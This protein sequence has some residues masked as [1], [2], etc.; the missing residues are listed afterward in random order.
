MS[1][2]FN[3][4][5][6]TKIPLT[7]MSDGAPMPDDSTK[8]PTAHQALTADSAVLAVANSKTAVRFWDS[9]SFKNGSPGTGDMI[10]FTD[11][12]TVSG[13]A[14]NATFNL[15]GDHTSTGTAL[16][17]SI[18]LNSLRGS[19]VD[20][21]GNYN[22]GQPSVSGNFKTITIPSTKQ[23]ANGITLLST[24]VLGSITYPG[25]PNGTTVTLFAIGIS[26]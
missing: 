10:V 12:M 15:T 14:G 11:S 4:S 1:G 22:P 2:F 13:G 19:W 9:G 23:S 5:D 7:S 20:S 21:Q 6:P 25:S 3:S 24:T 18:F 26:V 17:S 8:V 16:C